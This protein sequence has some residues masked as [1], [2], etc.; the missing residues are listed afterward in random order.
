MTAPNNFKPHIAQQCSN[1]YRR[2]K[3]VNHVGLAGR[4]EFTGSDGP[5]LGR[6]PE[7]AEDVYISLGSTIALMGE[8]KFGL[9]PYTWGPDWRDSVSIQQMK[10]QVEDLQSKGARVYLGLQPNYWDHNNWIR[11]GIGEGWL[12]YHN[13]HAQTGLTN[14]N[15]VAVFAFYELIREVGADGMFL[16]LSFSQEDNGQ[17]FPKLKKGAIGNVLEAELIQTGTAK[18]VAA[19]W[20]MMIQCMSIIKRQLD[21]DA[22]F[23]RLHE[24]HVIGDSAAWCYTDEHP[25][26]L[27]NGKTPVST[28]SGDTNKDNWLMGIGRWLF[29]DDL[30]WS[31]YYGS[32]CRPS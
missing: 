31:E 22:S 5:S 14:P 1:H 9:P 24:L 27:S 19:L 15:G 16:D 23:Y 17:G 28:G 8:A 20:K 21:Q 12:N 10:L 32:P 18:D 29:S 3:R 7:Y 6:I 13:F 26:S 25:S 30:D 4:V 11:A 2:N